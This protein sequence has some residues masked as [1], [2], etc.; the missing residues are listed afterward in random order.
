[1]GDL[2]VRESEAEWIANFRYGMNGEYMYVCN[3]CGRGQTNG[4]DNIFF[5]PFCGR[6]MKKFRNEHIRNVSQVQI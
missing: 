5:C 2:E 4:G 6:R 1:M 3:I